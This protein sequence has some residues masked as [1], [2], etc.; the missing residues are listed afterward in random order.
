MLAASDA[1]SVEMPLLT[2][3]LGTLTVDFRLALRNVLRQR[4][5]SAIALIAIGFGVIAMMLS[6]GYIEWVFWANREQVAVN[7]FGHI[8]VSKPGYQEAGRADPLAFLLPDSS[9]ALSELARIPGV[10]TVSPRLSFNGLLSHGDSTLSFIGEGID[11]SR[12]PSTRDLAITAGRPLSADDPKGIVLGIGL[13]A[14][15]GVKTGS[16]V[17]LLANTATGGINAIE[18][19]VRGLASTSMKAYDDTMLRAPLGTARALLRTAGAHLWVVGLERTEL[20][21]RV[22]AEIRQDSAFRGYEVTPWNQ[23]ADFYN[24]TVALFSR[25]MDVV[26]LIIGLIIVLS[27]S[28]TMSMSVMER[29]VEIGTAMALGVRR[30]RILGLFLLEGAL[31]GAIGGLVGASLGYLLAGLISYIGIPM[32]P[33]PGMSRGFIAAILITPAIAAEALLIAVATALAASVYPAWRA[34]RLVIVEALRHNR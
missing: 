10:R 7:Q 1:T 30:R 6:G 9:P 12:D 19:H 3:A 15:L 25:Q 23:L 20:T 13:A 14:N 33:A 28:N 32:P 8:Q 26:K 18:V 16:T 2:A 11:P 21:D 17:V 27:I 4:R 31:L 5:R 34:S 24:K 22:L 29:T